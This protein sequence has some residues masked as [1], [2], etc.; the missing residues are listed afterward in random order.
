M[1]KKVY[2]SNLDG[3]RFL[4]FLAVFFAHSFWTEYDSIKQNAWY[5]VVKEVT[6][7]GVTGVNFFFV[8]SGFLITY[9]LLQESYNS[10]KINISSFY[11]RRILK[12][13]PLYYI[14]V[15]VGFV[16][17]PF[18]QSFIG[19]PSPEKS[20][21]FYFLFFIGNFDVLPTSAVLGVLWSIAV[22]EQFYF[23]WPLIFAALHK[24]YY[25]YIFPVIIAISIP[26]QLLPYSKQ[27]SLLW[28]SPFVCMG[29]LAIG[30]WAAYGVFNSSRF[31]ELIL[32]LS[33]P[34]I[35]VV[36]AAGILFL[37]FMYQL[38]NIS[39]FFSAFSRTILCVFFA[40]IILEQNYA[41][42][43]FYKVS[44]FRNI[45]KLGLY[46]YSLYMT[47]MMC[48]YV[49]NK[50]FDVL[51]LNTEVYQV[52]FLQTLISFIASII[53]GWLSY[54]VIEKRFLS[55]KK[56]FDSRNLKAELETAAS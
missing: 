12:I 53:V 54:L 8:L 16:L 34:F 11:M 52:V 23:V 48:L 25:K 47:H 29:D 24:K 21:L 27:G 3:L 10:G 56:R 6:Y 2:F 36:Y 28:S 32:G 51:N 55:L 44:N 49:I 35:V 19:Q 37:L 5:S 40:F 39:V 41:K 22:E 1:K 26:I 33:R 9:L 43:S 14:V 42:N 17:V 31:R 4:A 15:L 30:G 20:H 13:W 18:V 7:K 38:N 50:I 46:T 45:S